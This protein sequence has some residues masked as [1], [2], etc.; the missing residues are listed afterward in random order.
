MNKT[1]LIAR[2]E[3]LRRVRSKWF[4]ATTLLAPLFSLALFI[5]P[6]LAFSGDDGTERVVIQD[7]TGLL[8][9]PIAEAVAPGMDV[10]RTTEPLDTLRMQVLN[11]QIDGALVLPASILRDSTAMG[12]DGPPAGAIY[13][14]KGS[15]LDGDFDLRNAVRSAVRRARAERAGAD[16]LTIAQFES[17]VGFD[18]ITVSVDGDGGDNALGRFLLANMLSLLVYI[19]ILI[20]GAMVM[21]GVIEEKANRIM[22]VVASSV[23][24][25][26][27]MM[28]KVLGI[29]AVGLTQ[30]IGWS[31]LMLLFSALASPILLALA[32]DTASATPG[33]DMPFDISATTSLLSPG[34]LVAFVLFFLG[35]YLLFSGLFAAVGSAVD[36][37]ADAQSLQ[38]PIMVPLVLPVLFLTAVADNPDGP[39][40]L[41]LSLFPISSPVTMIVRMAVSDVPWWQ[42]A[43]SLGLLVLAFVGVIALAARVYRVGI[44]M[45]GKKATFRDL[46]RWMRTA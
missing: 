38:A 10:E 42:V 20:Y 4:I 14:T 6:V 43:L 30:L 24:P 33:A 5:V 22:E 46:W 23:R 28:G 41:F 7:E 2:S 25:F 3:F 19:A 32:P 18:R 29:G 40:A 16:S 8:L 35:G 45:Y 34:L 26:E 9:A 11:G 44:L 1:A 37:E 15:G 17:P 31:L 13:Y 27:L 36:Q 21:R 39:L 12:A